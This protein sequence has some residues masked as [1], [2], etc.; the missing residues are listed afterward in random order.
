MA[1]KNY[2]DKNGLSYFWQK[3]KNILTGKVDKVD[4][5][6][7]STNDYTTT[8]KNKLN[9]IQE[10]ATKTTIDTA[11]SASSTNPVQNKIINTALGNKVDKVSGKGLSANDFTTD[12]K[13]KLDGIESGATN[14]TVDDELNSTSTNPVQNKI[15]KGA[16][17]KKVDK[18]DGKGLSTNDFTNALKALLE[19]QVENPTNLFVSSIIV[20]GITQTVQQGV[21]IIDL[22]DYAKKSE[23]ASAFKFIGNLPTYEDVELASQDNGWIYNITAEFTTD[24]TF[25]EGAGKTYPAGTNIIVITGTDGVKKWDVMSGF[26]DLS[27]YMKTADLVAITNDEI[28]TIL[29][30]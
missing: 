12:Y 6:G 3:I 21:G 23:V 20:D 2:V 14:T 18:V 1:N 30:S 5:K 4:G 13:N 17:D 7:L 9:G 28:D 16:L 25:N 8:E 15:V 27:P 29:A 10:G 22:S 11:L 26:V 19:A 24:A